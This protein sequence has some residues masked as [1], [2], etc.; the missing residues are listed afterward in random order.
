MTD[1]PAADAPDEADGADARPSPEPPE[2][3][4]SPESPEPTESPESPESAGSTALEP[5][6]LEDQPA[7]PDDADAAGDVSS[8]VRADS[9]RIVGWLRAADAWFRRRFVRP[10]EPRYRTIARYGAWALAAVVLVWIIVF[11]QLL[12]QRHNR[13]GT[14]SFDLGVY[15]QSVWLLSRFK[16][17]FITVRGLNQWGF[18]ANFLLY[19]FVPFY[20]LGAGPNLLNIA[21]C[22]S[23]G[24]GAYP[25]Y[26]IGRHYFANP[27]Y[28][29]TFAALYLLNPSLQFMAWESFHPDGMAI[30]PMLFAWWFFLERRWRMFAVACA[31]AVLWKEDVALATAAL[32]LF[33]VLFAPGDR[34]K[35]LLV[36]AASA[37]Y[38]QFINKVFLGHFTGEAAFYNTWFGEL[39]ESPLEI[40]G[41]MVRHPELVFDRFREPAASEYMWKMLTPF[42]WLPVLS[43]GAAL[44]AIPQLLANVLANQTFFHDYRYHYASMVLVGLTIATQSSVRLL[45]RLGR[46]RTWL[47]M[48]LLVVCGVR[49]ANLWGVGPGT[50]NYNAGFWAHHENPIDDSR[51]EALAM[52]P[53]DA[54]VSGIYYLLVHATQR[55]GAYDFP[56][57]FIPR[58]WGLAGENVHDPATVDYVLFERG[59]IAGDPRTTELVEALTEPGGQFDIVF[60]RDG[61]VLAERVRAP[62]RGEVLPGTPTTTEAP[63]P[64]IHD[65]G[66]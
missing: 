24:L 5:V 21:F 66:P 2:P 51:R 36:I 33:I 16:D 25:V 42:G 31:V 14:Y 39:G 19:L 32:G 65:E 12:V 64:T 50:A 26:R 1:E 35:G 23:L 41:N 49:T 13:F 30:L 43:I 40:A 37:A 48:G 46:G 38:F 28:G 60:E 53:D 20:W 63:S 58:N 4:E 6:P 10:V 57:P 9:F 61:V 17:P 47:A 18:H 54:S 29:L 7:E 8:I 44:I 22:I 56:S 52:I 3:P 59:I 27:A 45:G 55:V 15:D 62:R 34:K 11:A